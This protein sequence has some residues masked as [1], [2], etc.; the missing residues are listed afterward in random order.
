VD[1][2][3]YAELVQ[4]AMTATRG[5]PVLHALDNVARWDHDNRFKHSRPRLSRGPEKQ[6]RLVVD[7]FKGSIG[8]L[9][10]S[11]MSF[12]DRPG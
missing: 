6:G 11:E 7:V 4:L 5:F 3:G 9:D 2:T 8:L 1:I 10:H 12:E